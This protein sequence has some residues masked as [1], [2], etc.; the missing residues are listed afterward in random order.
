MSHTFETPNTKFSR[1]SKVRFLDD[2][3]LKEVTGGIGV[4]MVALYAVVAT[5]LLYGIMPPPQ[6]PP[7]S[8]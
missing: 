5:T 8:S 3:E 7:Y 2:H 1:I 4:I 6:T